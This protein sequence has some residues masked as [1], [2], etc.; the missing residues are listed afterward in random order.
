MA[1]KFGS[2]NR[3]ER[4]PV[5]KTNGST[6]KPVLAIVV[7]AL[8]GYLAGYFIPDFTLALDFIGQLFLNALKILVVPLIFASIIVASSAMADIGKIS[9]SIG[10]TLLYFLGTGL[11][12]AV[13]GTI[14]VY[15]LK[16]GTYAVAATASE[17]AGTPALSANDLLAAILPDSLPAAILQGQF[18][19]LVV[20]AVFF[21]IALV[22]LGP[23]SKVIVDLMQ[24]VMDAV[25]K[26]I[27]LLMWIAPLGVFSL[28]GS[29][30]AENAL[31]SG[32]TVTSLA[33]FAATVGLG[34]LIHGLIVLPLILKFFGGRPVVSF[35]RNTIPAMVTAFATSSPAAT[36]PVTYEGSA[37]RNR[38]DSRSCSLVLP[39]GGMINMNGTALYLCIAAVFCAQMFQVE[40]SLLQ[41]LA[42]FGSAFILSFGASMVPNAAPMLLATV[43][44]YAGF[45]AVAF[46]GIGA[47]LVVDWFLDR[48]RTTVNVWGDAVGTAVISETF[49][50]KTARNIQAQLTGRPQPDTH[51][52]GAARKSEAGRQ[53]ARRQRPDRREKP[54]RKETRPKDSSQPR[55]R[56]HSRSRRSGDR[57]SGRQRPEP[58]PART[59]SEKPRQFSMPTPPY[60]VLD[61]ELR[62]QKDRS[63]ETPEEQ[64]VIKP[65]TGG[66]VPPAEAPPPA[67]KTPPP[68]QPDIF[69]D[70]PEPE[71][72]RAPSPPAAE[73][74]P[75]DDTTPIAD[76]STPAEPWPAE[77][78]APPPESTAYGR[79]KARRGVIPKSA[80][81]DKKPDTEEPKPEEPEFSSENISF[82]R[83]KRKK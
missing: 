25:M 80:A 54:D 26:L 16:P 45:P 35:F 81:T 65:V 24:A 67:E 41:I 63:A 72:E 30:V 48:L 47:I 53:Q 4:R 78:T 49:D 31:T 6:Y 55:Q 77:E 68:R 58:R 23:K 22:S 76:V 73:A 59:D 20:F 17:V 3:K 75:G 56:Q 43:M 21:G 71:P 82:G 19:S 74:E 34:M 64:P 28:V 7:G 15:L 57:S 2:R 14:L 62:V 46:A 69:E 18:L 50:F 9:R 40:L 60:H 10:K 1:R 70:Q 52:S 44:Y 5:V 8:L 42:V 29:A 13:I 11:V 27:N 51:R 33:M 38:V 32:S 66:S 12:A 83:S 36:L 39:L 79:S 37:E 61:K